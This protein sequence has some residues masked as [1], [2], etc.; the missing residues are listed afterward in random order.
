[1]GA[2][3]LVLLQALLLH[4]VGALVVDKRR[5][6]D[7]NRRIP[8]DAAAAATKGGLLILAG[9]LSGA[10]AKSATAPLR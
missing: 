2:A 4:D 5:N 3:R 8:A 10:L 6:E 1:M 7:R 9:G